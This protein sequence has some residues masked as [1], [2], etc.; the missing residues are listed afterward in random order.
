M[1]SHFCKVASQTIHYL[2]GGSGKVVV[3]VPSLWLTS[4]AFL[5]QGEELS[6]KFHVYIPD[7]YKGES[8]FSRNASSF[9][10]YSE[11]LHL[12]VQKLQIK[13]FTLI[14]ISYSGF[15]STFYAQT[16]PE[17]LQKVLLF[18]TSIV[19]LNMKFSVSLT[20]LGVLKM[21]IHN[22]SYEK[23]QKINKQWMDSS[24]KFFLKHPGQFINE[25]FIA[26]KF[27]TTL[28]QSPTFAVPIKLLAAKDDEFVKG[29]VVEKK[30]RQLKNVEVEVLNKRHAWNFSEEKQF[31]ELVEKNV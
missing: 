10:E 13:K 24:R 3:L 25:I 1:Q 26:S 4:S 28:T 18:S 29:Y 7:I 8:L 19:S 6:K 16:Y 5:S 9:V 22:S 15:I 12:F 31:V 17:E 27:N 2:E 21:L 20:L 23:G 11:M 30:H 14:G